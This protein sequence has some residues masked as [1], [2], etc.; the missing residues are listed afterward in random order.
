MYKKEQLITEID[1]IKSVSILAVIWQGLLNIVIKENITSVE[2]QIIVII[3]NLVKFSA[4]AFIFAICFELTRSKERVYKVHLCEKL[5]KI[6]L[7]YL[8]WTTIYCI[9]FGEFR[10]DNNILVSYIFGTAAPHLWYTVMM[11]QFQ[12]LVPLIWNIYDRMCNNVEKLLKVFLECVFIYFIWIY[13][14]NKYIFEKTENIF[15]VFT[16]RFF[17]SYFIY[18]ILGCI[19]SVKYENIKGIMVKRRLYIISLYIFSFGLINYS[20]LNKDIKTITLNSIIYIDFGMFLYNIASILLLFMIS[21]FII[22]KRNLISTIIKFMSKYAFRAYLANVF[23]FRIIYS[24]LNK[25]NSD[26]NLYA[27]I[28]ILFILTS[29]SSFMIVYVIERCIN[30]IFIKKESDQVIKY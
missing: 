17:I 14:Y 24:I 28:L 11:F 16:D 27:K 12:L 6:I 7:P 1:V 21:I 2:K 19:I 22:E 25:I 9:L 23:C 13:I 30:K 3:F 8:I 20:A 4:P 5:K 26:I 15:L 10:N 29:I 18:A